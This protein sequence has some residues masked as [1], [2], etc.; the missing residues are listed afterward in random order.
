M[1]DYTT[2]LIWLAT[3]PLII[4]IGYKFTAFN[5][6]HFSRVETLLEKDDDHTNV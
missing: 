3:W 5:M 2:S 6:A 1:V 4:Y